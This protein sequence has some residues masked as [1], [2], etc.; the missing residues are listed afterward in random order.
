[1]I[2]QNA[3]IDEQNPFVPEETLTADDILDH[4]L[5]CPPD[6]TPIEKAMCDAVF[7]FESYD[8]RSYNLAYWESRVFDQWVYHR[9]VRYHVVL[10][11]N[12]QYDIVDMEEFDELEH[13]CYIRGDR[14]KITQHE[15]E[16]HRG[17]DYYDQMWHEGTPLKIVKAEAHDGEIDILLGDNHHVE[18]QD[19]IYAKSLAYEV[20]DVYG[21]WVTVKGDIVPEPGE[22]TVFH[23]SKRKNIDFRD[24][25]Y[26][27]WEAEVGVYEEIF[28]EIL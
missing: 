20:L 11:E 21:D 14:R 1:M 16:D 12:G 9:G 22:A 6:M 15:N 8:P 24:P 2:E 26:D 10:D 3:Y 23:R 18:R 27:G 19:I 5:M 28:S 7:N 4:R 13:D 25:F 17:L